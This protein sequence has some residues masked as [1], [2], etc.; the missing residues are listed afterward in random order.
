V[1]TDRWWRK[2]RRKNDDGSYG[3][4]LNRNY[5]Y[6]WSVSGS[7]DK[8]SSDTFHGSSAFSEPE[9]QA[10][11]DLGL[12]YHFNAMISY[13]SY[14]ELV[15]FP[16]NYDE[17]PPLESALMEK[18]AGVM[19]QLISEVN[20]KS[21][22][23]IQAA[24]DYLASGTTDDWF[25]DQFGTISYTIELPPDGYPYFELA[26]EDIQPSFNENLPATLALIE[27]SQLENPNAKLEING[28]SNLATV[29]ENTALS[30]AIGME[31]GNRNNIM[32]DWWLYADT[33]IGQYFY[34]ASTGS[35]QAGLQVSYQGSAA[36]ISLTEVLNTS[37]L[38]IG[39]YILYFGL[40]SHADGLMDKEILMLKQYPFRIMPNVIATEKISK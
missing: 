40:E 21:Y 18:Q 24:Y 25:Y 1:E 30:L 16:W 28:S 26:E 14:G 36:D 39:N 38:P 34:N 10:I 12:K 37:T 15:L 11:R 2:N 7:S 20:G 31:A 35:W 9:S 3:V 32:S 29:N 8:P 27:W 17:I 23:I 33:P 6:Q 19:G 13:H 22:K 5:A 4:D